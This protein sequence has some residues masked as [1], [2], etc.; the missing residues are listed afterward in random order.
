M[1]PAKKPATAKKAKAKK[2]PSMTP[3]ALVRLF[4]A[5]KT[6]CPC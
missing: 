5:F 2:M 3:T 4:A 6:R 1:A